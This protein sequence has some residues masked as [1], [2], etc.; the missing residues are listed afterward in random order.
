MREQKVTEGCRT[1]CF[2]QVHTALTITRAKRPMWMRGA[3]HVAR[4]EMGNT[5]RMFSL[6]TTCIVF[7][8]NIYGSVHRSMIQ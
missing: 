7:K 3:G 6:K 8:F 1:L 4:L 5:H 2:V